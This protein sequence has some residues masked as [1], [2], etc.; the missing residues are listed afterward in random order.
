VLCAGRAWAGAAST[1]SHP[2]GRAWICPRAGRPS[3][4]RRPSSA[5]ATAAFAPVSDAVRLFGYQ[6]AAG[7]SF[8]PGRITVPATLT[9]LAMM[10]IALL[11]A[12]PTRARDR[13]RRPGAPVTG[14]AHA[15]ATR[16]RAYH[17]FFEV[18]SQGA[19]PSS[20]PRTPSARGKGCFQHLLHQAGVTRPFHGVRLAQSGHTLGRAARSQPGVRAGRLEPV[21]P[22]VAV[23]SAAP[24]VI[25]DR[26]GDQVPAGPVHHR[27]RQQGTLRAWK[28]SPWRS[29]NGW[30]PGRDADLGARPLVDR[31]NSL[32]GPGE[33]SALALQLIPVEVGTCPRGSRAP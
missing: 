6:A 27:Q 33:P 17:G 28:L 22:A 18:L 1:P 10:Y 29:S 21:L 16:G 26:P 14:P 31:R 2:A 3:T 7:F 20:S 13:V 9:R 23:P 24:P 30:P 11:A 5:G 19:R 12:T 15:P 25:Q 4:R 32:H 8:R